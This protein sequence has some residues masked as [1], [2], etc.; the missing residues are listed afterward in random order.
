M[1]TIIKQNTFGTT[2]VKEIKANH[3]KANDGALGTQVSKAAHEKNE[4]KKSEVTV[5][6][7]KQQLNK[8][9]LASNLDVSVSAGNDPM[10]LLF[11][12]AIDGINDVL[13]ETL[14]DDAIQTAYDSGLDV[15]PEATADRIVLMST[16][17]FS[18][19]QEQHTDLSD[20]DAAQ[21]FAEIISGGIDQGFAEA[22]EILSGL[23][24]LEGEIAANIDVTYDLVQEGLRAF[25]DN[26]LNNE[27]NE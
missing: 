10:A 1:Q 23:K 16:A 9:I 3:N 4:I 24:V 8:S 11:K 22:R 2:T 18:Q 19:Y 17:F 26:Y 21:S 14:G 25:V 20:E 15:S 7:T 5:N 6:D 13:K 27:E 12:A